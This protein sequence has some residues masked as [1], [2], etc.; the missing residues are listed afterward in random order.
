MSHFVSEHTVCAVRLS[1]S[2]SGCAAC[3]QSPLRTAL[4]AVVFGRVRSV[5]VQQP[6]D[7]TLWQKWVTV[8]LLFTKL[9]NGQ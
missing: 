8:F 5:S 9:T 3:A 7:E 4:P 6:A 1:L 2:E